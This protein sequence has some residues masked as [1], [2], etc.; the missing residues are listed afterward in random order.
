MPRGYRH[1]LA[2]TETKSAVTL[3]SRA[4]CRRSAPQVDEWS[5]STV[6]ALNRLS[7]S[8]RV[9]DVVVIAHSLSCL[10]WLGARPDSPLAVSR[11]LLVAP[12][13]VRVVAGFDDIAAFASLPLAVSPLDA[14]S[15]RVVASDDDPFTPDGAEAEFGLPLG[16]PTTILPGQQHFTVD[17]GYG[18]WPSLVEWCFDPGATIRTGTTA[19]SRRGRAARG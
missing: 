19:S 13:S 6:D 1:S 17:S 18:E 3:A 12:P 10:L 2:V 5:A 16:I 15:T 11:V 8:G 4:R 7:D 9:D 14:R